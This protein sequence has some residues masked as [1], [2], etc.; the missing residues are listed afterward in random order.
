MGSQ[1]AGNVGP[2]GCLVLDD[3]PAAHI[4]WNAVLFCVGLDGI[5]AVHFVDDHD[6]FAKLRGIVLHIEE[7]HC[8]RGVS[9][10]VSLSNERRRGLPASGRSAVVR[11]HPPPIKPGT[12]GGR[13]WHWAMIQQGGGP[14]P[15]AQ[16]GALST[17]WRVLNS[18]P[19]PW[20]SVRTQRRTAATLPLI[21]VPHVALQR[22]QRFVPRVRDNLDSGL[23]LVHRRRHK[24]RAHGMP[25]EG[26]RHHRRLLGRL[27]LGAR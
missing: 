13:T 11:R 26:A 12:L 24:A 10:L 7:D 5:Q 20:L 8:S 3:E 1:A 15:R 25:A 22:R 4:D 27:S 18:S 19:F 9:S 23:I 6:Y 2:L 17:G 14:Y 16:N 21:P